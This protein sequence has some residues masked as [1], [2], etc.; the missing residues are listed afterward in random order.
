MSLPSPRTL[1]DGMRDLMVNA[2]TMM[3]A[4]DLKAVHREIGAFCLEVLLNATAPKPTAPAQSDPPQRE[5]V[6]A[7]TARDLIQRLR[8]T[9]GEDGWTEESLGSIFAYRG[10]RRVAQA[11][12]E[13]R[14]NYRL[15]VLA[16]QHIE[17]FL[18]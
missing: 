2:L 7:S 18:K 16:A 8:D 3:S 10:G 6:P 5:S 15:P 17:E 4:E 11:L 12:I 14:A 13:K 9:L 1:E